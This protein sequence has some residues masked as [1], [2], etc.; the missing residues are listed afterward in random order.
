MLIRV[1]LAVALFDLLTLF[2]VTQTKAQN[3]PLFLL[4]RLQFFFL[5]LLDLSPIAVTLTTL[6][7]TQS[8]FFA[9]GNSNA[10][11]SI[12]LSNS[13]NGV[14]G[15]NIFAVGALLFASN[16]AGPIYFSSAGV[17]LLGKHGRDQRDWIVAEREHLMKFAEKESEGRERRKG[18]DV[19]KQHL[20]LLTLGVSGGLVATM[21]ACTVLREHLF[22][23]TVFSPK[24][25]FA[26]AWGTFFHW[27]V[28]L[29][30]GS[31]L[32]AAGKL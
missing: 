29:G 1:D 27:G 4:F 30:W 21:A 16:W 22:V 20:A 15:Y 8:S 28:S 32:W 23:W 11:S 14:S 12:S 7:L 2:L 31:V 19:W 10:I 13:Y 26:G 9:L 3:I 17:L 25:L 5:T 24:F 6:L 18:S